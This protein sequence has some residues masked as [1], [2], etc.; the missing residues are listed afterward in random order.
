MKTNIDDL[1][2]KIESQLPRLIWVSGNEPLLIIE[3]ADLVRFK[4]RSLGYLERVVIDVTRYTKSSDLIEAAGAMSLFG[5]RRLVELRIPNGRFNKDLGETL[6]ELVVNL[7]DDT[8]FLVTSEQLEKTVT[9]AGWLNAIDKY[10]L[11]I[12][13]YPLKRQQMPQWLE[14]RFA[15]QGQTADRALLDWLSDKT[16]GN[17]LAANQEVRK[18]GLLCERGKLNPDEV[19]KVVLNVARFDAYSVVDSAVAGNPLRAIRG[20]DGLKAEGEPLPLVT[21][22]FSE[23]ARAL[24]KLV[25]ARTERSSTYGLAARLRLFGPREQLFLQAAQRLQPSDCSAA[26]SFVAG[27]DRMTKGISDQ[28][29]NQRHFIQ[30]PWEALAAAACALAGKPLTLTAQ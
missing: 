11:N 16:E 27:A 22:A 15:Q 21:F 18:L 8:R 29:Q 6:S 23:A 20:L 19:Q 24:T 13:I 4:A 10:S 12:A 2:K 26:L 30:D 1:A 14:A 7:S 5:D 28:P 9:Q 3:A 17:L 25:Q